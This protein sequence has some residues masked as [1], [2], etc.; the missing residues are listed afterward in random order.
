[1]CGICGVVG[2]DGQHAEEGVV[3][4]MMHAI[5]H[6]GPDDEGVYMNNHVGLGH[7]R[8]SI[9]DLSAA[10]HQPMFTSDRRHLIVF[11]GEIYNYIELKKEL[12]LEY[13]FQT[14]T[15]T[16]VILAAYLKWGEA[17]LNRFNGDF[18][19]V[20]YDTQTEEIFG[21][22]DR[23][24]IKPFYYTIQENKLY[25][26]SE[27]KSL[28]PVLPARNV[29]K[30]AVFE[31]VVYNR[32]DQN[33]D[34]F[35]EGVSKVPHGHFFT[36]KN[37]ELK[38]HRWYNIW[39]KV[40]PRKMTSEEYREEISSSISL[41]L[42]SDVPVGVSLSG[43]IDSSS[44]AASLIHDFGQSKINSFS[45]VYGKHEEAD[46]S[47]FIDE[48][49]GQ[50]PNMYYTYPDGESLFDDLEKFVVAHTEPVASIGPYAQFK[51]MELAKEHVKVTIDGQGADEQ[52]A[53]YH[54]F[55]GSYFKELLGSLKWIK[56]ANEASQYYSKHGSIEAFKYLAYYSVPISVK[57]AVS[58][59]VYGSMDDAFFRENKDSSDIHSKLYNPKTLNESLV[60]HFEYK[61]EHLLKWEDHNGMWFSLEPRVPFLDHNLVEKT[62]SLAPETKIFEGETKHILRQ[63]MAD[64]LPKKITQRKDKKGFST[65]AD[66]WF[67]Q[68]KF[69]EL[70]SDLLHS[71]SFKDR[72]YFDVA[73]CQRRYSLHL[74]GET[75][76]AKDI[77]KWV[78][79]EV[80][81]RKFVD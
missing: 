3:R 73:D 50:M 79:M 80:W 47:S 56:F 16:E 76:I 34:T 6:R 17:C 12:E 15:D 43:G 21:A 4:N 35:F 62:L 72:G 13:N 7:V 39:D 68:P 67:R 25:F 54:Y 27:I 2:L 40:S 45:A 30:A 52:L 36:I 41:R 46:E 64:V 69:E 28:V 63:A 31:Y 49:K 19:F 51:V 44:I 24:G 71:Q 70:I 42:R 33:N 78:N 53:G 20:I 22:R 11:N 37:K 60:Q 23:Y 75:D 9:I 38:F 61:L 14:K 26:S 29:N 77:W 81:H 1:M 65:P 10:G 66:K 8:L 57:K 74:K 59:N 18:A 55:F 58:K 48:F 32:T 5:K